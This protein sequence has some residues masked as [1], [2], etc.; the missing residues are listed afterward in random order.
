MTTAASL[1]LESE[2]ADVVSRYTA[3]MERCKTMWTGI[4]GFERQ[5]TDVYITSF[6][7]S[8]TTLTQQ[9]L[10][11]MLSAAGKIPDDPTGDNFDNITRVVPTIELRHALGV[12]KSIHSYSPRLW[13]SHGTVSDFDFVP[14]GDGKFVYCVRN[15][16]HV[17]RSYLDFT[18]DWILHKAP[19]QGQALRAEVYRQWF[20]FYFLGLR[21]LD[22]G[23]FQRND[24]A[25]GD[26]FNHVK[27]WLNVKRGNVFYLIYEDTIR[28]LPMTIRQLANFLQLDISEEDIE[29]VEKKCDRDVMA[30]DSRFI[31]TLVS[32]AMGWDSEGGIR[33]RSTSLP[34]FKDVKLPDSCIEIY[35]EMF[36]DSFGVRSYEDLLHIFRGRN[37]DV[38]RIE[39]PFRSV[40]KSGP[41]DTQT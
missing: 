5:S 8:G 40:K 27:E 32:T 19:V 13:K 14:V 25:V 34:G 36:L 24:G 18:L 30:K 11:Q 2:A 20:L 41:V 9:I 35:N 33:V 39:G 31:D 17:A 3:E 1:Q 28:N 16:L 37:S 38:T 22:D 23:S 21:K 15:G 6:L 12:H 4:E 10:Y 7:K 29:R 26:W